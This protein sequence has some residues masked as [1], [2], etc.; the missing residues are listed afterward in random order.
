MC[1]CVCVCVC[2]R[3]PETKNN[4]MRSVAHMYA[5]IERAD[6]EHKKWITARSTS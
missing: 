1:V 2:A 6:L 5:L 3:W 4:K